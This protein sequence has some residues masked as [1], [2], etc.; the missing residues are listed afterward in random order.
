MNAVHFKASWVFPFSPSQT[1]AGPFTT[2]SGST[3]SVPFMHGSPRS[4]FAEGAGWQAADLPYI[5]DASMTVVMPDPGTFSSFER[6]L[7]AKELTRIFAGMT[8]SD[9]TIAMPKLQL[10]DSIN[11]IPALQA[12]GMTD[13]FGNADFSG[14]TN[15]SQLHISQV[16]HQATVTIDETGT[17]AAAATGISMTDAAESPHTVTLDHPYLFFIRDT[18]T[19][20]ILFMGRVTDPTQT[21]VEQP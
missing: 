14:I 9:L 1:Q 13:A 18:K 16:V 8:Q 11:L 10:K 7:D 6:S 20:A 5:G 21:S 17:E 12:L 3:V 4:S 2:T 15:P 19:G